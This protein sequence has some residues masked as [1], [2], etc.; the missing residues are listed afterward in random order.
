MY[1]CEAS[2][3]AGFVQ[4]LAARY[5][6]SGYY[7]YV[8]GR[9]PAGKDPRR[10]D[11]KLLTRY[12]VDL[13]KFARA[14]RKRAGRANV[15]YLRYRDVFVLLATH[16]EHR[17]FELEAAQ[18]R[19]VRREPLK[20]EGY[21]VGFR[22]GRVSVRIERGEYRSL[23]AYFADLAVRRSAAS[24][25]D[26]L[27]SLPYEPYAPVRRQLLGLLSLVNRTRK[28]AGL[29]EVPLACLRLRRR[30]GP[31]YHPTPGIGPGV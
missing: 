7:F 20:V 27:G 28:A 26:E 25:A 31:V 21:A 17:F 4:Q 15:H 3:L 13:S 2:S 14:R 5:V 12:G 9:V 16:G 19:D 22:A 29:G 23:R 8:V 30:T 1:R 10:V 6:A 24:L 18:I 11:A